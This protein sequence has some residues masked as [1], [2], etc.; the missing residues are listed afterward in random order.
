MIGAIFPAR[1][2][3]FPAAHP[4]N[5]LRETKVGFAFPYLFVDRLLLGHILRHHHAGGASLEGDR[6]GID[7][8]E[9]ERSVLAQMSPASA[10][11]RAIN[12]TQHLHEL[13]YVFG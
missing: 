2:I 6:S 13:L 8:D 4:G 7:I 10:E 5:S 1:Q 11:S 12:L 3:D 9:D